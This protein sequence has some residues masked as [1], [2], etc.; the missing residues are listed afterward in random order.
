MFSGDRKYSLVFDANMLKVH[1]LC[2]VWMYGTFYNLLGKKACV[3]IDEV[4]PG[5]KWNKNLMTLTFILNFTYS[6]QG[7]TLHRA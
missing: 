3:F 6:D 1:T 7:R 2:M 5:L 4:L